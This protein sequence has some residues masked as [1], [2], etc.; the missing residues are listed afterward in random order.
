MLSLAG[1]LATILLGAL[2]GG[3]GDAIE[4]GIVASQ[5]L[6]AQHQIDFTRVRRRKL[7]GS[8]SSCWQ[9]RDSIRRA[10][11]TCSSA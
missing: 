11:L 10:W 4:G 5:G 2:G 6:A 1:M 9:P 7:I 3:G 8:A